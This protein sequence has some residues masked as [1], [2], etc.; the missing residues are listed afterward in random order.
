[1]RNLCLLL[2]FLLFYTV[3]PA[4]PLNSTAIDSLVGRTLRTFDVPGIAVC[5]IKDGKVVDKLVGAQPKGNFVKKIEA[6]L[7]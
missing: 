4:Q 2:L 1:M 5:V 6:H 3:V 7:A